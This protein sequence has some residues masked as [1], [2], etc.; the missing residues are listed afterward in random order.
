MEGNERFVFMSGC[1]RGY[2]GIALSQGRGEGW[3]ELLRGRGEGGLA[4]LKVW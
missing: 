4:V 1:F 2:D 3:R